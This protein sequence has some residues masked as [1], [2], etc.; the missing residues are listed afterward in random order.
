MASKKLGHH[1]ATH[2]GKHRVRKGDVFRARPKPV[3]RRPCGCTNS[4]V[5]PKNELIMAVILRTRPTM[6]W[7]TKGWELRVPEHIQKRFHRCLKHLPKEE[8]EAK[9]VRL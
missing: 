6:A 8:L 9:G 3:Y 1:K 7:G 2:N 5:A 4:E